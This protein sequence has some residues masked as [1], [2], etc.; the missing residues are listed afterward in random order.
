VIRLGNRLRGT[1]ISC[2]MI[3]LG[4]TERRA[5]RARHTGTDVTATT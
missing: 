2:G 1:T 5:Q 3:V 4:G